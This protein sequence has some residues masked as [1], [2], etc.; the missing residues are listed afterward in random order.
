M[1]AQRYKI[2][3]YENAQ[4]WNAGWKTVVDYGYCLTYVKKQ[5]QQI[6]KDH[7]EFDLRVKAEEG[8]IY[9]E[10]KAEK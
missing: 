10:H 2:E 3:K 1:K 5:A 7:P 8:G 4:S 9:W 6:A